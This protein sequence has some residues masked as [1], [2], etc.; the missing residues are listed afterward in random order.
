MPGNVY[1]KITDIAAAP[2]FGDMKVS[3]G[4]GVVIPWNL[5]TI[6]HVFL[7]MSAETSTLSI[8]FNHAF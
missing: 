5:S 8:N 3:Y 1:D 2:R 7:G 4:G 6:I